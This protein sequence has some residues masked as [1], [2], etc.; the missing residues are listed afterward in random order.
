[1]AAHQDTMQL[2]L[3]DEEMLGIVR[4]AASQTARQVE[5]LRTRIDQA[6]PQALAIPS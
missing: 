5:W 2:A 4:H 1:M 6:A 3:R